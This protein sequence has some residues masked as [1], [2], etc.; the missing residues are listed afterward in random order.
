MDGVLA[1]PT[2]HLLCKCSLLVTD[3]FFPICE[4]RAAEKVAFLHFA[5][6]VLHFREHEK[7]AETFRQYT[8]S[9]DVRSLFLGTPRPVNTRCVFRD[10]PCIW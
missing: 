7:V 4:K 3:E 5:W 6:H 8:F 2:L 9:L 1:P 10:C